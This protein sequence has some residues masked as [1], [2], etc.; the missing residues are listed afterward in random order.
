MAEAAQL[1]LA[2]YLAESHFPD[3][4]VRPLE[5]AE[6]YGI[7]SSAGQYEEA[8]DG[9]LE[10][11][12][13]RF[14]MFLNEDRLVD[15]GRPR[16]RF[17]AA[18]EL[19]HYFIDDHR[20]ALIGGAKAHPSFTE[21]VTDSM[22]EYQADEFAA[23]LLM[24]PR[25]FLSAAQQ[26]DVSVNAIDELATMFGTSMMSTAIRYARADV[27]SIAVILWGEAQRRWCWS[28]KDVWEITHN[29]AY[30]STSRVPP[31]SVTCSLL[32]APSETTS[33]K[34]G[35]ALSEWFPFV[36]AGSAN[37]KPCREEAI[38]LGGFGVL[39]LLEVG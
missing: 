30:R 24:P 28:S 23:T 2:E 9:L 25:R 15:A 8:F 13:G 35:T 31:G 33:D 32:A 39:T 38:R 18:H 26:R 16:A 5:I 1:D 17:T 10:F 37:D 19:G 22:A 12:N 14:H 36:R 4:A 34:R 11:R 29:K 3:D 21:F 27:A 7:T 20:N 6:A